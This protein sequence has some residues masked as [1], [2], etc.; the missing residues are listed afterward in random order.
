MHF[1]AFLRELGQLIEERAV[2]SCV[3]LQLVVL[4]NIKE[5]AGLPTGQCGVITTSAKNLNHDE[6]HPVTS[7]LFVSEYFVDGDVLSLARELHRNGSDQ[8]G[9]LILTENH[10]L[11]PDV[12][13]DTIF[14]SVV[15]NY[16]IGGPSYVVTQAL[17]AIN[18][19]KGFLDPEI[20]TALLQTV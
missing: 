20:E 17:R 19:N 13:A 9:A 6:S 15:T 8:R 14:A 5:L 7:L 18:R 3:Y 1:P 4:N 10:R 11:T 16:N 2:I 12:L